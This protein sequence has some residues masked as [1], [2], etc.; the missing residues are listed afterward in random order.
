MSFLPPPPPPPAAGEDRRRTA[1]WIYWV[2]GALAVALIVVV[3]ILVTGGDDG[4]GSPGEAAGE[5][6]LEAA[7]SLGPDPYTDRVMEAPV[8]QTTAPLVSTSTS[9]STTTSTTAASGTTATTQL[10]RLALQSWSGGEP[11]LYG[12]TQDQTRCDKVA[13]LAFLQQNP[14]KA[15]AWVAAQ[16]SDPTLLWGNGRRSLTVAELPAYFAELTPVTLLRDTRVTN[17]GYVNGQPT[18]RQSVLQAGTAVLVD[19]YGVPRAR[20]ACGNPLIPPIALPVPPIWVGPTWPGWDPTVIIV[21]V[22]APVII[23]QI[24][25][26]DLNSGEQIIRI[27][28]S[29]GD[30]DTPHTTD[31]IPEGPG[32]T[33]PPDIIVGSGDVQ[34]TLLWANDSDMDLHVIDPSGFEIFYGDRISPSGG[35][36]DVD[37]IPSGGDNSTHVEN[38]FWAA[39]GAPAGAY[40]AFVNHFS[41]NTDGPNSYTLEVKVGGEL[42]HRESG[43]L[44]EGEDS[45]AFQFTVGG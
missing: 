45:V 17:H 1:A 9:S 20:C 14:A 41:S 15:A 31:T 32:L 44:A 11:G 2:A 8:V 28:G 21:V 38:V 13:M 5:V 36:L 34:V 16:N 25:I 27:P 33:I 39:E 35:Q 29:N 30:Q 43:T 19:L 12:G 24:I 10:G 26:I 37:D 22:P 23:T 40:S 7:G 18:A 42:I 6:Y 4:T 3:V